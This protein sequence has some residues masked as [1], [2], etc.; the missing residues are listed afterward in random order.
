MATTAKATTAEATTAKAT[1]VK[2][3]TAK[4]TTRVRVRVRVSK[5]TQH[6]RDS[7]D[8]PVPRWASRAMPSPKVKCHMHG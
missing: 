1:T 6:S 3:T 5:T 2:T 8:Y 7:C 4:A